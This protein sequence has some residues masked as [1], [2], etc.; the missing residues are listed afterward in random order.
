MRTQHI[1]PEGTGPYADRGQQARPLTAALS[2]V[3]TPQAR[4][5]RALGGPMVCSGLRVGDKPA[6]GRRLY[7]RTFAISAA[8]GE[9]W[10]ARASGLIRGYS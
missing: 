8:Q 7:G 6:H 9:T 1:A 4:P 3:T 2:V 10:S 5:V